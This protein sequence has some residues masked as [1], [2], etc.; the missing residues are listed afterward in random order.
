MALRG[1]RLRDRFPQLRDGHDPLGWLGDTEEAAEDLV[2]AAQK[3]F[4]DALR[5]QMPETTMPLHVD[6]RFIGDRTRSGGLPTSATPL[7]ARLQEE[8]SVASTEAHPV[9]FVLL[10]VSAG[11]AIAHLAPVYP[12]NAH[13]ELD[14]SASSAF[15]TALAKVVE[16]HNQF[17]SRTAA[18]EIA[19]TASRS[20]LDRLE[21]VAKGLR[22]Q[23]LDLEIIASGHDG[24]RYVSTLSQARGLAWASEVFE[25]L[26]DDTES[27]TV[28]GP[29]VAIDSDADTIE[30]R[31][32][33]KG[34]R[35]EIS[36]V[37]HDLIA[38]HVLQVRDRVVVNV[39]V[40]YRTDQVGRREAVAWRYVSHQRQL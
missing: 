24:K 28:R 23:R 36:E 31:G 27:A 13:G 30:V 2:G 34:G 29:I 1:R 16:V 32:G 10:D 18:S 35:V 37:P 7:I 33:K 9:D 3:S 39:D 8:L 14:M 21:Q 20:L 40:L 26:R 22:E 25:E 38:D 19:S 12:E 4:V 6:L 17:E 5:A 11:S 15:E